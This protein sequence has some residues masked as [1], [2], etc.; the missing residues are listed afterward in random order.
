MPAADNRAD[1]RAVSPDVEEVAVDRSERSS[2]PR[3]R[4]QRLHGSDP[5][6][7][8]QA[9][10]ELRIAQIDPDRERLGRVT[11]CRLA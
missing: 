3:H 6:R 1:R 11:A 2:A 8:Q 5:A 4:R 9:G 10:A 7:I